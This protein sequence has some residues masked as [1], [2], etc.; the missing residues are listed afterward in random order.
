MRDDKLM[1]HISVDHSGLSYWCDL[2]AIDHLQAHPWD[3]V[4]F[5]Q[6]IM[7]EVVVENE[8]ARLPYLQMITLFVEDSS[9]DWGIEMR[10]GSSRGR[11]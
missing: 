4:L 8:V 9:F 11:C 2:D 10:R 6:I 7:K 5:V 1:E 3:G